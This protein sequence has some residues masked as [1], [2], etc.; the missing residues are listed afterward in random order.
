[1]RNRRFKIT[2]AVIGA[3]L[4]AAMTGGIASAQTG[5]STRHAATVKPDLAYFRGK[6]IT[7]ISPGAPGGSF[8]AS[9][10]SIAQEMGTFLDATVNVVDVSQG[11]T[12][13][14]QDEAAGSQP[15]GLTLG[16]LNVE[17]DIESFVQNSPGINFA[18]KK[19]AIVG[20]FPP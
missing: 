18:L 4:A 14:G 19:A 12:V 13:P 2:S 1:M 3:G 16:E 6:T 5:N 20:G 8:D 15:N 17:A 7:F 9:A 10:R 11:V